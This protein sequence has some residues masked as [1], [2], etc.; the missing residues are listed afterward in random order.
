[1]KFIDLALTWSRKKDNQSDVRV[2]YIVQKKYCRMSKS[3]KFIDYYV[4]CE[5]SN[6]KAEEH[7]Y[8]FSHYHNIM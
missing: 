5:N 7:F 6:R 1:M 8:L 2:I 3:R 4:T